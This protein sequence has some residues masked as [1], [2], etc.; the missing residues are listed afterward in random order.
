VTRADVGLGICGEAL[1][2][3]VSQ[4]SLQLLFPFV[5]SLIMAVVVAVPQDSVGAVS[6]VLLG[7]QHG[8]QDSL[9]EHRGNVVVVMVVT[10][11]RLRN[12]KPWERHL[13]ERVD[14]VHYL[15][16]ADV[17]AD[18][19]ATHDTVAAKIRERVPE[20]VSVLI[21]ME[22]VWA[23]ELQLDT[24]RPNLLIIDRDGSLIG[25]FR[26]LFTPELLEPVVD[27]I[28]DLLEKK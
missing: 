7:D 25:S 16:I 1:V 6:H 22:R 28:D 9:A 3:C 10:A 18:S 27:Q 23:T 4:E 24:E 14:G 20:G 5:S 19:R 17:P 11:K 13:R 12:I 2:H 26:G 15:R 8:L 21:D